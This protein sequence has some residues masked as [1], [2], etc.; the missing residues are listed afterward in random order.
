MTVH[1]VGFPGRDVPGRNFNEDANAEQKVR[2]KERSS[3]AEQQTQKEKRKG[4]KI[5]EGREG[6]NREEPVIA[7][8]KVRTRYTHACCVSAHPPPSIVRI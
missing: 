1:V 6:E 3:A 2:G 5:R 4:Q 8:E 7:A